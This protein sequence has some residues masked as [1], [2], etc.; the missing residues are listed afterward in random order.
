MGQIVIAVYQP[1]AGKAEALK[2][3]M[4]THWHRLKQE[5]LVT[6]RQ[7]M[8]MEA[9]EGSIVEVFEWLSAEAIQQAHS[10][11]EVLKMW[12][13]YSEVCNYIPLVELTEAKQM[14]A[15]FKPLD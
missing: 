4:K 7:S 5:G 13:E 8:M 2:Q 11:P 6:D 15:A 1:K 10:N 14:F 3:L 12:G 9:A